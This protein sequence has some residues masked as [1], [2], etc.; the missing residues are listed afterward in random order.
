MPDVKRV[1]ELIGAA[2]LP[3]AGSMAVLEHAKRRRV[4]GLAQIGAKYVLD[5]RVAAR[6]GDHIHS[7]VTFVVKA[8]AMMS[9]GN[10]AS[11]LSINANWYSSENR[12]APS[13]FN[14]SAKNSALM[15]PQSEAD[16]LMRNQS[17]SLCQAS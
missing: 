4:H 3:L 5:R 8:A 16:T 7:G 12:C 2:A 9:L 1:L 15:R 17:V 6:S 10:T 14:S 11:L 13:T